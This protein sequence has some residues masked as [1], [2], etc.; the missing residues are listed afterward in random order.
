M[1]TLS[2]HAQ[3]AESAASGFGATIT[4]LKAA[5]DHGRAESIRDLVD[6]HRRLQS[7]VLR[8]LSLFDDGR[9]RHEA[10]SLDALVGL[11]QKKA[12]A[13]GFARMPE[14][15]AA[16]L[17]ARAAA[18]QREALFCDSFATDAPALRDAARELERL[19]AT[20]VG[21]CVEHVMRANAPCDAK[22]D[23]RRV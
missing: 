11:L 17:A 22:P 7:S 4:T 14:L 6:A 15:N 10:R 13:A 8:F 21:L 20:L 12:R 2:V 5:R 19:D 3:T 23:A 9:T 16:V 1:L 18:R